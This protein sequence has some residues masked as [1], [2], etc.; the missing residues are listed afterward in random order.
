MNDMV[1]NRMVLDRAWPAVKPMSVGE[2]IDEYERDFMFREYGWIPSLKEIDKH[3]IIDAAV[4]ACFRDDPS[5]KSDAD[6]LAHIKAV[7]IPIIEAEAERKA[8]EE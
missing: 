1:E 4:E 5:F 2:L 8:E 7:L 3:D 6:K